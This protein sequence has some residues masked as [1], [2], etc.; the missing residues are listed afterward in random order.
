MIE[1]MDTSNLPTEEKPANTEENPTPATRKRGFAAMSPERRKQVTSKGGKEAHA[2]GLANKF[3]KETAREAG[4]LGGAKTGADRARMAEIGRLGGL[5]R[6]KQPVVQPTDEAV[7][8]PTI[9]TDEPCDKEA[10]REK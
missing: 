1:P 3:T 8:P 4:K 10:S 7:A 2:A 9:P 6:R 5:A